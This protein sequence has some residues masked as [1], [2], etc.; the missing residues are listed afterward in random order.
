MFVGV[1]SACIQLGGKKRSGVFTQTVAFSISIGSLC[2]PFIV[3]PF[4]SDY[5]SRQG[6]HPALWH[7]KSYVTQLWILGSYTSFFTISST[8]CA[9]LLGFIMKT[10]SIGC[11]GFKLY[12]FL[13]LLYCLL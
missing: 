8:F 11:L 4:L 3:R 13:S 12:M 5:A 2:G 9:C 6:T 7:F 1:M 10:V